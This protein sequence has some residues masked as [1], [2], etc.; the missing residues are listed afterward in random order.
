[1][2]SVSA[3][4]Q[5]FSKTIDYDKG[6]DMVYSIETDDTGYVLAGTSTDSLTWKA[7]VFFAHQDKFGNTDFYKIIHDT[8]SSYFSG[9]YG[10]LTRLRNGGYILGGSTMRNS[11]NDVDALLYRFNN[12]G[13]TIFTSRLKSFRFEKFLFTQ[14]SLNGS[15]YAAGETS[16]MGDTMQDVFVVKFDT[17]GNVLWK[18]SYGNFGQTEYITSFDVDGI[19][20][21]YLGTSR[22][23]GVISNMNVAQPMI[24]KIDSSGSLKWQHVFGN[25]DSNYPFGSN[26][27]I[28]L[29]SDNELFV[30]YV[31]SDANLNMIPCILKLDSSKN[32]M[33]DKVLS[34]KRRLAG[35]IRL[36]TTLDGHIMCCGQ[37]NIMPYPSVAEDGG[38][39]CKFSTNGNLIW[40]RYYI[41]KQG[42]DQSFF[43]DI[44]TSHFGGYILAGGYWNSVQDIWLMSTDS[45]GCIGPD[46]CGV[47]QPVALESDFNTPII[48]L[49]AYPN[50]TQDLLYI[51]IPDLYIQPTPAAPKAGKSSRLYDPM[52]HAPVN[53]FLVQEE[54]QVFSTNREEELQVAS[55]DSDCLIQLYAMDGRMIL[56]KSQPWSQTMQLSVSDL[57]AGIYLLR[58]MQGGNVYA[59]KVVVGR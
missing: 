52:R 6:R 34:P 16:S 8:S 35:A 5:Y 4:N 58:V 27:F 43:L 12:V 49:L 38:F 33:F 37:G 54:I 24:L 22:K 59:Q 36:T 21:M 41:V 48:G 9:I 14:E 25:M 31:K 32:V 51:Q 26:S 15:W 53:P 39:I 10:G 42:Q 17:M 1:M 55:S 45:M 46:S 13:D 20:N 57:P 29:Y 3:Q 11:D 40:S 47:L 56:S 2:M 44:D 50:P 30:S 19:G 23:I 28:H 7:Y 18:K